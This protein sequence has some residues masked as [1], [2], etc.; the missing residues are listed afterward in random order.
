M[1]TTNFAL[2]GVGGQGVLLASDILAEVGVQAGLDV[3][4]SEVHGMAQRGGS[5]LSQIIWGDKVYAPLQ[6][7]GDVDYLVSF[8]LLETLRWLEFLK[9]TGIAIVNEQRLPPLAVSSGGM[10]YP[11]QETIE[12]ALGQA[13]KE[14]YVVPALAKAQE[15]GTERA[16]NVVLLGALSRHLDVPEKHWLNV[17][18]ERVPKKYVELNRTAFAA[19]RQL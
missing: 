11:A 10:E 9:P 3:K 2:V 1:K 7:K 16:T 18:E 15:L 19:G 8:E 12:R 17:I 6:G 4:K 13:T 5:V 14:Y